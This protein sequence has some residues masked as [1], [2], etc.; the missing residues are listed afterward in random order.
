MEQIDQGTRRGLRIAESAM[1]SA[2]RDTEMGA[3]V[4]Q[5]VA[6]QFR[7]EP[8]RQLAGAQDGPA[9]SGQAPLREGSTHKTVIE[10]SVVGHE[11]R[12]GSG[13]EPAAKGLQRLMGRGR[14]R[15][16]LVADSGE[17]NDR[18]RQPSCRANEGLKMIH[19]L[20]L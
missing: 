17:G 13:I 2:V 10:G 1:P 7:N 16:G 18:A 15:H 11:G 4:V 3:Q 9:V 19:D 5:V 8:S 12:G 20:Q 14:I 6:T